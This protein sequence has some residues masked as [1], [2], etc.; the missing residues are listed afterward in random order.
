MIC[1][2]A[3]LSILNGVVVILT[4]IYFAISGHSYESDLQ[5]Y[6]IIIIVFAG[7]GIGS[8][9]ILMARTKFTLET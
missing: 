8:A 1:R 3:A 6:A 9:M 2:H 7:L 4:I 5:S